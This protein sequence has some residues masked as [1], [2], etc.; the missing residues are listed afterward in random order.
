V[1]WVHQRTI[2]LFMKTTTKRA[3]KKNPHDAAFEAMDAAMTEAQK[4]W[5][6]QVGEDEK[7]KAG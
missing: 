7:R 5:W 2:V 4:E 6:R 1:R 3:G